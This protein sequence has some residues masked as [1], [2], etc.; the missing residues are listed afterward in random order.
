MIKLKNYLVG[1]LTSK[2]YAFTARSWELRNTESID[3]FDSVGSTIK[4]STRGSSILRVLPK[5]NDLINEEW[6]TDKVRFSYDAL[7][8]QR[9]VYCYKKNI[10]D[11]KF[12]K[13]N[14]NKVFSLL[15]NKEN[16]EFEVSN[17]NRK[18]KGLKYINFFV[19][20][21]VDYETLESLN[22]IKNN[23]NLCGINI[24]NSNSNLIDIDNRSSYLFNGFN[25]LNDFKTCLLLGC[26]LRYEAPVLNLKIRKN[27]VS[28]SMFV[29]NIGYNYANN[30]NIK[31]IGNSAKDIKLFL[32]NKSSL[33]LKLNK[34]DS[35]VIIGN[36]FLSFNN[37]QDILN[38]IKSRI[39]HTN[40]LQSESSFLNFHENGAFINNNKNIINKDSI[41]W[42]LDDDK[43]NFINNNLYNLYQG[44]H[45]DYN[46]SKSEIILPST[47][48]SEKNGTFINF[49]GLNQKTKFIDSKILNTS[50]RDDVKIISSL[51]N[52]NTNKKNE[53][54]SF[55]NGNNLIPYNLNI[56]IYNKNTKFKLN[57]IPIFNYMEDFYRN[58]S[59]TKNSP[60]MA[61]VSN[62]LGNKVS[63]FK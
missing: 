2:P 63:S 20:S 27:V 18:N 6:I 36:S 29:Y 48:F 35:L 9:I 46:F 28:K 56:S 3:V 10:L 37:S 52:I 55:L 51:S 25:K 41:N 8:F 31:N 40:I 49:T 54:I 53:E 47:V 57:N 14:W 42:L 45:N 30:F 16:F 21:F 62:R 50:V 7:K 24:I 1:A 43:T 39:K 11:S 60:V 58:D 5:I 23:F 4:L 22:F 44:H 12:N 32:E 19:G 26:N 33:N 15:L 59:I 17:K 38:I 34:K 61:L 13:I